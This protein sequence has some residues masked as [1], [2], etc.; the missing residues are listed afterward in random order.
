MYQRTRASCIL[1]GDSGLKTFMRSQVKLENSHQ[2]I[3]SDHLIV[4]R[5]KDEL[6]VVD[7]GHHFKGKFEKPQ[8]STA[9]GQE[10]LAYSKSPKFS[11]EFKGSQAS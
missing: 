3:E 4:S 11:N 10:L 8:D 1:T 2:S 5:K 9:L 6:S 7:S